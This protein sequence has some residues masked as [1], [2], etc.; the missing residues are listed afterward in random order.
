MMNRYRAYMVLSLFMLVT[1][2]AAHYSNDAVQE[3]YGF[4]SGVWHGL[5]FLIS[6]TSNV[7]SWLCSLVGI[8]FLD[9]IEIVG[10]PNSGFWYYVGFAIGLTSAG[11]GASK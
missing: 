2:C 5:I 4:F 9:S 7:I 11:G 3:P 8:S 1:G 10:R 6:L